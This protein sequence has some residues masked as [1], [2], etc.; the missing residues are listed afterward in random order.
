M[1][2]NEDRENDR[3]FLFD[4]VKKLLEG[5]R[6]E[7]GEFLSQPAP[8]PGPN[9][10]ALNLGELLSIVLVVACPNK[11]IH[12]SDF[13]PENFQTLFIGPK[14]QGYFENFN[15][16]GLRNGQADGQPVGDG[17]EAQAQARL[18]QAMLENVASAQEFAEAL[19]KV[20]ALADQTA[21]ENAHLKVANDF[22][23]LKVKQYEEAQARDLAAQ[24]QDQGLTQ[25]ALDYRVSG[26]NKNGRRWH[27]GFGTKGRPGKGQQKWEG[28]Q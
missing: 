21:I 15:L 4:Q 16:L 14:A 7:N 8:P 1:S 18:G 12:Y 25:T 9:H 17:E 5:V 2:H 19:S 10:K 23:R 6:G 3:H 13:S 26:T 28:Q 24:D 11:H 27:F 22:L 20:Q